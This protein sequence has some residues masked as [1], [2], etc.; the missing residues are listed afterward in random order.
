MFTSATFD[1]VAMR[2]NRAAAAEE[3]LALVK[4]MLSVRS[5]SE[6]CSEPLLV[7]VGWL[8]IIIFHPGNNRYHPETV[9]SK[10]MTERFEHA[11]VQQ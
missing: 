2:K 7:D 8:G 3:A 6:Q 4:T 10:G 5:P 9:R 1:T 11:M